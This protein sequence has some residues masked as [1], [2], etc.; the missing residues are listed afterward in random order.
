MAET[1]V[2]VSL[3]T[4]E[5]NWGRSRNG[6]TAT[7]VARLPYQA[8][9]FDRLGIRPTYFTAYQV[10][11]DPRAAATLRE[12]SAG[13]R[14]EIG[15]HLHPWNTPPLDEAFV[16][17]NS[18][19]KN[20]PAALQLAK[21]A[22][23]TEALREA[24]G[25]PPTA[26]RAGRY[27]LGRASVGALI[28]TGYRVDSSVK[29]FYDL[30]AMDDGPSFVGAPISPYYL[31]P[32]HEVTE[33]AAAGPL[34]ELPLSSG[35]N[36]GPF[37]FWDPA[38]R[39]LESGAWRGLRLAGIASRTG[40]VRR[41]ALSPELSSVADMLTLSRRLLAHGARHLHLTWHTPTLVP[42][43][44]P[45]AKT[46]A[47]VDRLFGTIVGFLDGLT[48]FTRPTFATVSEAATA[49]IGAGR[50]TTEAVA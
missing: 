15:A 30:R 27:G 31:S 37:R 4:E 28:A 2:V 24:F 46:A 13:G 10:A 22:R 50:A 41:L 9:L 45:F 34:I 6:V 29:P 47:D 32:D 8:A 3:D 44:S 11:I 39:A 26:F 17:R 42:G 40:I 36:R 21:V 48:R 5:D 7:N 23:L 12:V 49:L 1:L 19:M 35:F 20:L 25:A 33:P 16:P 43:L 18:M 38:R 14:G